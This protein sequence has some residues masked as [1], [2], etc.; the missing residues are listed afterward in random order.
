MSEEEGKK[1]SEM[2][3]YIEPA[4]NVVEEECEQILM[5]A[6]ASVNLHIN[7]VASSSITTNL[8]DT[9]AVSQWPKDYI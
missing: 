7:F 5:A 2:N 6:R 8:C 4:Y 9:A 3:K 1:S